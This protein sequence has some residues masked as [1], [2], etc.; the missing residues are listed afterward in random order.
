MEEFGK[1]KDLT[2]HEKSALRHYRDLGFPQ[3]K[4][5]FKLGTN[6]PNTDC[7]MINGYL[8]GTIPESRFRFKEVDYLKSLITAIETAIDKSIVDR[9]FT[10]YK[11]L[12]YFSKLTKYI[13]GKSV[14][15]LGFNS[16]S[17]SIDKALEYSGKNAKGEHI[18]FGLDLKS[19]DH[20]LYIDEKEDE[21]LIQK[22]SEFQV[23]AIRHVKRPDIIGK[24]IIYY[25][26]LI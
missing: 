23:Y 12:K 6:R 13:K 16:F 1:R 17:T 14:I 3:H 26:K 20:A 4:W 8:R 24:A 5:S 10:V 9:K 18:L 11:G 15:D 25:L 7:D 22:G 19:G 21:W 2:K